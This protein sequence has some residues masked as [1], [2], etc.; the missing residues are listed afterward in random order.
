M[1]TPKELDPNT[2]HILR[3]LI[4]CSCAL[5][6]IIE[7]SETKIFRGTLKHTLNKFESHFRLKVDEVLRDL[8]KK[9]DVAYPVMM[10]A[11]DKNTEEALF[12]SKKHS[13]LKHIV[14]MYGKL[15]SSVHDIEAIDKNVRVK[16]QLIRDIYP[17][18]KNICEFLEVQY[19]WI[20]RVGWEMAEYTDEIGKQIVKY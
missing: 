6:D 8:I 9:D 12:S 13:D 19:D 5:G 11:I 16:S 3:C 14:L 20:N 1:K 7:V 17:K 18:L 2:I 15:K 10:Q 4:K